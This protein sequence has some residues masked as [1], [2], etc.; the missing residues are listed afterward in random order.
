MNY[1]SA[2]MANTMEEMGIV[3]ILF[4]VLIYLLALGCAIV[5]YVLNSLAYYKIAKRRGIENPWLSWIPVA[6]SWIIGRVANEY[7]KR[8]GHDRPWHKVLLTLCA[9]G[10]L[11]FALFYGMFFINVFNM[12]MNFDYGYY[13]VNM[14]SFW[15]SYVGIII[16][17][18]VIS[19]YSMISI[20]CIYKT[21][22]STVPEKAL[23]Y[24]VLYF[25]VPLAGPICLVK[26]MDKGYEYTEENQQEQHFCLP[27]EIEPIPENENSEEVYEAPEE[28]TEE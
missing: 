7:D 12:A 26:C 16:F 10:V 28:K 18:L 17:A 24:F 22:E 15:V 19:V 3:F 6:N 21:F 8:N 1:E 25:L 13:D 5:S 9:I 20:I 4:G 14:N 23:K 27:D 11:G 2:A